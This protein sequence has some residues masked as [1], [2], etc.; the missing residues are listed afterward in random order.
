[1]A[2]I[3]LNSAA[4]GLKALSTKLD[5]ISNNLANSETGSF[6]RSRVNFE[7]LVYQTIKEPGSTNSAGEISPSGTY[8]GLGVKVSNTQIDLEQGAMETTDRDLDIAIE[9]SGGFFQVKLLSTIGNGYGYT[10]NGNLFANKDGELVVGMQDGYVI[11]PAI[12]IPSNATSISINSEGNVEYL[13]PGQ[14]NKQNAGQIMLTTFINPQGLKLLGGSIYQE[15]AASGTAI[16]VKPG[17][18]GLGFI[19]QGFLEGSNVDPVKELVA[20]IKTQRSFDLNSQSI[21]AADQALQAIGNLR[22]G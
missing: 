14:V 9:G 4:T 2:I 15:T 11:Q 8:V 20:L 6:K 16:T 7:D 19:R 5:V 22:R 3:A 10:R 18:N 1:M 12:K 13:L 17:E 21:Q